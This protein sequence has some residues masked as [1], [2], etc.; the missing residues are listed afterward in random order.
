MCECFLSKF[1]CG[2]IL[3]IVSNTAVRA[4][5]GIYWVSKWAIFC[6]TK[7]LSEKLLSDG[8]ITVNG[9][10]PGPTKTDM[11]FN[12]SSSIYYPAMANKRIGLP[13]E[14]AELAFIQILDGLNGKT[15]EVLICDG[16]E[17]LV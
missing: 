6:Y 5:M 15:G 1:T 17:S 16:G 11:M 3:N 2:T 13:E 12:D 10:C 14:I 9:L 4:A 7:A 8:A